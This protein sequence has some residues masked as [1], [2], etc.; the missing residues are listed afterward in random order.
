MILLT[1]IECL[2]SD[3]TTINNN[4]PYKYEPV[5]DKLILVKILLQ[6]FQIKDP[7]AFPN[8]RNNNIPQEGINETE[9]VVLNIGAIVDILE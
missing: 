6:V 3:P 9:Y 1:K 8:K 5:I 7:S 2:P 4:I